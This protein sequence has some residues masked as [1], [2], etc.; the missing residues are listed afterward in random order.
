MRKLI[1]IIFTLSIFLIGCSPY[2]IK[3]YINLTDDNCSIATTILR[4]EPRRTYWGDKFI[5]KEY[6]NVECKPESIREVRN[7]GKKK[8][9]AFLD[10]LNENHLLPRWWK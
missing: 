5:Y 8:A 4:A 6:K 1:S 10:I 2:Y 3:Q 7:V 9:E